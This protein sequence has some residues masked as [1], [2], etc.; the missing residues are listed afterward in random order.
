MKQRKKIKHTPNRTHARTHLIH[1]Q[2]SQCSAAASSRRRAPV[3]REHQRAPGENEADGNKDGWRESWGKNQRWRKIQTIGNKQV[4]SLENMT[5]RLK[6]GQRE[7]GECGKGGR[8]NEN[9]EQISLSQLR[10]SRNE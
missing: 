2:P 5:A 8:E 1:A 3:M 6:D 4:G 9:R 7:A 10:F